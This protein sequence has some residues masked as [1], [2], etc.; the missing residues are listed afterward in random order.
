MNRRY[1]GLLV[2]G[3]WIILILGFLAVLFASL[4]VRKSSSTNIPSSDDGLSDDRAAENAFSDILAGQTQMRWHQG[5]RV[6]VTRL[7]SQLIV[8]L[9]EIDSF[10]K[11]SGAGCSIDQSFCL[12]DASSLRDGVDIVFSQAEPASLPSKY[13]WYGGFVDPADGSSYDLLGR[14]YKTGHAAKHVENRLQ[15]VEV[16]LIRPLEARQN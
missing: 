7:S 5:R 4:D 15:L 8:Q 6:W 12:I 13:L 2:R 16:P 9:R 11:E 14:A 10:V 1:L 3:L